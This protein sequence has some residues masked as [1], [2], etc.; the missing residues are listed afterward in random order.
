LAANTPFW[1]GPPSFIVPP[2]ATTGSFAV[3]TIPVVGVTDANVAA[4]LNG[5]RIVANLNLTP[6]QFTTF[7]LTD[8]TLVGGVPTSGLLLLNGPA[9]KEGFRIK[10][11]CDSLLVKAPTTIT[12][13]S[14]QTSITFQIVTKAVTKPTVTRLS[15]SGSGAWVELSLSITP[16]PATAGHGR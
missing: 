2:G 7:R 14:G 3:T 12:I 6:A 13:P 11:S 8:P 4:S 5:S 10:I 16:P 15:A 1:G 9:P